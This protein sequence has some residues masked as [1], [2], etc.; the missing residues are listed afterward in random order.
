MS[1]FLC[2][3]D[4]VGSRQIKRS[5]AQALGCERLA[6]LK[7]ARNGRYLYGIG[8]E[9]KRKIADGEMELKYCR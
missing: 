1:C 4:E 8:M 9:I 2:K 7:S 6:S 3:L 5:A